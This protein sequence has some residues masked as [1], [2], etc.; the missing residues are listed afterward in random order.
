LNEPSANCSAIGAKAGWSW[1]CV[2]TI[3][4]NGRTI[5][6]AD[7]QCGDG[8]RFVLRAEEKLTGYLE[9]ELAILR[10]FSAAAM[11]KLANRST[12]SHQPDDYKNR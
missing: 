1:G 5:G 11:D 10:A 2:S 7:A 8:K 3:D 12:V 6:I 4:S 9:L